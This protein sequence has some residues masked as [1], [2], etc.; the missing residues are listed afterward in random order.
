M[1][2]EESDV[3]QL[4]EMKERESHRTAYKVRV[5]CIHHSR[6]MINL[7][8]TDVKSALSVPENLAVGVAKLWD[9]FIQKQLQELTPTLYTPD[10]L[11]V[12]LAK[13]LKSIPLNLDCKGDGVVETFEKKSSKIL[14]RSKE[15]ATT[16][17]PLQ[18]LP[19]GIPAIPGINLTTTMSKNWPSTDPTNR[20]SRNIESPKLYEATPPSPIIMPFANQNKM[21]SQMAY[22]IPTFTPQLT[23]LT[24]V[25]SKK[26]TKIVENP[27]L[28]R[29]SCP[30][31]EGKGFRHD[32]DVKH[33]GKQDQKCK[34]CTKCRACSV[35][36]FVHESKERSHDA[37]LHLRCFFCHDCRVCNGSGVVKIPHSSPVPSEISIDSNSPVAGTPSIF[38]T[39]S[40]YGNGI[41]PSMY[42]YYQH[43]YQFQSMN[44]AVS[45]IQNDNTIP[46]T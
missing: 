5:S 3:R 23:Q 43:M 4:A 33:D 39:Y 19:F 17:D 37:P 31:C 44:A 11:I 38:P 16:L 32:A 26:K 36:G 41:P 25:V 12:S 20:K 40:P 15:P 6:N 9:L 30:R 27:A 22:G 2:G 10:A 13:F 7:V 18:D 46:K 42:P 24:R 34:S 35:K 1:E 8:R 45:E 14:R 29:S 21:S 28:K